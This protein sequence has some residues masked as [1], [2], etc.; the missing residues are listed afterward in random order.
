MSV[1]RRVL[2][3]ALVL[4]FVGGSTH[5][6]PP[7]AF[8]VIVNENN[9]VS[10]IQRQALSDMLLKKRVQWENGLA[11]RP[12]DLNDASP[13]REA[14][15]QQIHKRSTASIQ[16]YWQREIFNGREVPPP[17]KATDDDVV[18]YV[19]VHAGAVG[20]VSAQARLVKVKVLAVN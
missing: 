16:A 20:Y 9:S 18:T 17:E 8:K 19:R 13:V 1:L 5:A 6:G 14:F 2:A 4:G 3:L 10:S 7:A 15:S 12:V 11:V